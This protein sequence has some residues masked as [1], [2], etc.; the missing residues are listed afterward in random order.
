LL[1]F[2]ACFFKR[3][4]IS[5][6]LLVAYAAAS[7]FIYGGIVTGNLRQSLV[8]A[9]YAF[10]YTFLREIIKDMED[11]EADMQNGAR[12][13]AIR[14][15]KSSVMILFLVTVLIMIVSSGI[16]YM[17]MFLNN[18]ILVMLFFGVILPLLMFYRI[19][20]SDNQEKT[21]KNISQLMKFDMF[22]LLIIF[23]IGDKL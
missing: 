18:S 20:S 11:R 5:G 22:L 10:F 19:L 14:W 13:L 4:F 12:T 3:E 16:L 15:R 2:Y 1:F 6:N 9:I 21:Y 7:T 17:K 8:I 23:V